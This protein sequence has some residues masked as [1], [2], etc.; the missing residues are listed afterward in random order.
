MELTLKNLIL[1][2]KET[3]ILRCSGQ[4]YYVGDYID[5]GFPRED[6]TLIND[7]VTK[8]VKAYHRY[9]DCSIS[10]ARLDTSEESISYKWDFTRQQLTRI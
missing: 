3:Y 6:L 7:F 5:G 9:V 10:E 1:E 8:V 2:G 4:T